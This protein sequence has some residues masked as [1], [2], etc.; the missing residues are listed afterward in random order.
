MKNFLLL[1]LGLNERVNEPVLVLYKAAINEILPL[2]KRD[3]DFPPECNRS[4]WPAH[5]KHNV[6]E[7]RPSSGVRRRDV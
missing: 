3:I 4:I 2:L 7:C 5:G 1:T 6:K